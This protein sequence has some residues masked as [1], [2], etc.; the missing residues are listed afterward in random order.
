MI[1]SIVAVADE[2]CAE[3]VHE[4]TFLL[5]RRFPGHDWPKLVAENFE[6]WQVTEEQLRG[7]LTPRSTSRA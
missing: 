7:P 1:A 6:R 5:G 3:C 2:G 4:L